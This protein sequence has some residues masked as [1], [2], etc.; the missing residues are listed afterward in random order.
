MAKGVLSPPPTTVWRATLQLIFGCQIK[1]RG[2][3]HFQQNKRKLISFNLAT[4]LCQLESR[5]FIRKSEML[6]C[7]FSGVFS[8]LHHLLRPEAGTED[9]GISTD[10]ISLLLFPHPF[11]PT[12]STR[13][14]RRPL[15]S[16]TSLIFRNFSRKFSS[17]M[18]FQTSTCKISRK[19]S[20]LVT[21]NMKVSFQTG[22]I[23][24]DLHTVFF[25]SMGLK[26]KINCH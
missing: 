24:R 10:P 25:I 11:P 5:K 7:T 20:S 8:R 9:K 19:F 22:L 2:Q 21:S 15:E 4:S 12:V 23:V 3:K 26:C 18:K 6:Y 16:R 1:V 13:N 17:G 14:C